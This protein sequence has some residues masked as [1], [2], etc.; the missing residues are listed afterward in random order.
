MIDLQLTGRLA[1]AAVG[2]SFWLA[3]ISK[4]LEP[5]YFARHLGR[6]GWFRRQ[7]IP[8]LVVV[9]VAGQI[10]VGT[11][12]VL[13]VWMEWMVP[14][15]AAL[16]TGLGAVTYWSITTGRVDNCGCYGGLVE[17][18]LAKS[19]GLDGVYLALLGFGFLWGRP[20]FE[21]EAWIIQATCGSGLVAGGWTWFLVVWYQRRRRLLFDLS[22]L[23]PGRDWRRLFPAVEVEDDEHLVVFLGKDCPH[24]RKW[25]KLLNLIHR[26]QEFPQVLGLVGALD[27]E[28]R[29]FSLEA[30]VGF[31]TV[32]IA[33]RKLTRLVRGAFPTAVVLKEGKIHEKWVASIPE[34]VVS[35]IRSRLVGNLATG[36]APARSE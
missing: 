8:H 28:L 10:M 29:E 27:E 26:L 13:G 16:I 30:K 36:D 5:Q 14:M 23:R 20:F 19:L 3:G 33:P 11:A 17:L 2:A 12:L 24:C 1:I 18:S 21:P 4:A 6:L 7:R 25:I 15:A 34:E 31:P 22:P 35:R 9:S 32:A